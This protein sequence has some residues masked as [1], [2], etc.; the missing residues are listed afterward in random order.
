MSDFIYPETSSSASQLSR[1]L[2]HADLVLVCFEHDC[3]IV[4]TAY[5]ASSLFLS[6][7]TLLSVSLLEVG[8]WI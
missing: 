3:F 8:D 1:V 5:M 6:R 2:F 7:S 4:H